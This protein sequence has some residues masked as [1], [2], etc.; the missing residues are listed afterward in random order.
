MLVCVLPQCT[1]DLLCIYLLSMYMI[2]RESELLDL[3]KSHNKHYIFVLQEVKLSWLIVTIKHM[4][5]ILNLK[6]IYAWVLLCDLMQ[7]L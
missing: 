1:T 5:G 3:K 7:I 4:V 2:Y 6:K